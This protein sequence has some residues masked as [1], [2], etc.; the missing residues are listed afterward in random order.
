MED[1]TAEEAKAMRM[2]RQLERIWPP[3]LMIMALCDSPGRLH[4]LRTKAND[5]P[6]DLL[7]AEQVA[8]VRIRIGIST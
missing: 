1:L 7:R 5:D 3:T 8:S 4:V 6:E 2:L